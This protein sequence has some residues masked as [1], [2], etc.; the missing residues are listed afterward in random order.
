MNGGLDDGERLVDAA[1]GLAEESGEVLGVI[2]KH[3]FMGHPL[4]REHL[5]RE[6]GDALWCL[7]AIATCTGVSLEAVA[8]GNLEKLERRYPAGYSDDAS[9]LRAD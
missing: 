9:R 7:A 2:R 1:A 8:A 6:L 5:T 4:D 3:L